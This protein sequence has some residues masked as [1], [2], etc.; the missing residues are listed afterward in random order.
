MS[1]R[2]NILTV[3]AAT[4]VAFVALPAGAADGGRKLS[5]SL[6]GAAEIPGPGDPDG[7]GTADLRINP[8][9]KQICYTLTVRNIDPA[10]GAH[11]H[12]APVGAAGPVVVTLQ[13]PASGSSQA[14]A[15]VSREL[16]LEILK[17]PRDYYVNVH[18]AIYPAGALRG[19]LGK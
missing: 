19:Q 15:T 17:R 7:S 2:C 10:S 8:G 3:F 18:N 6:T 9:Q 1:R 11:I 5:T 4:T 16:A 13:K 14:C 12:E